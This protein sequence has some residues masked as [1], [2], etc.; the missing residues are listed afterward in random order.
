MSI[1][2]L[3]RTTYLLVFRDVSHRRQEPVSRAKMGSLLQQWLEWH[4]RLEAQGRLRFRCPAEPRI[5][6]PVTGRWERPDRPSRA[7]FAPQ[8]NPLSVNAS[9]NLSRKWIPTD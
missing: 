3:T 8:P 4:D 2:A 1:T 6:I 7:R 5:P 9:Q